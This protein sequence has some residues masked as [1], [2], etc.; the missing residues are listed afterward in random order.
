MIL[1]EEVHVVQKVCFVKKE[2]IE[3][4][5]LKKWFTDFVKLQCENQLKPAYLLAITN[6]WNL[7]GF[8]LQNQ[9]K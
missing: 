2:K 8:F 7:L 9:L 3:I 6:S 4:T 5:F 1:P